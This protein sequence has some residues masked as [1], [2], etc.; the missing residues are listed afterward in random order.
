[1]AVVHEEI[2]C[3]LQRGYSSSPVAAAE[4]AR[5]PVAAGSTTAAEGGGDNPF[6][7]GAAAEGMRVGGSEA[8]P[9][10]ALKICGSAL[11][12]PGIA[13]AGALGCKTG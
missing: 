6:A 8:A 1:M 5:P 12:N 10:P 7:Y 11:P 9:G 2:G 4:G 13:R 3:G